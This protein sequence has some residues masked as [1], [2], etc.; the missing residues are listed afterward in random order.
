MK[1]FYSAG[2]FT[3]ACLAMSPLY[4]S[5]QQLFSKEELIYLT[6]EWKGERFPDGRPKVPDNII[7]RIIAASAVNNVN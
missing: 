3:L 7:A 4:S 5:A 6:P 2:L 1:L